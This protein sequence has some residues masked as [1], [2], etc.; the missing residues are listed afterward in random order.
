ML[1]N[2]IKYGPTLLFLW[3]ILVGFIIGFIRGFRK[4]LIL[5]INALIAF[6]IAAIIYFS[7]VNS[8]KFDSNIVTFINNILGSGKLQDMFDVPET[9]KTLSGIIE[10]RI[11]KDRDY[12]DAIYII[13]SNNGEYLKTLVSLGYHLF[14]FVLVLPIYYLLVF[15]LYIIY[16]I[17]FSERRYKNKIEQS[18]NLD[19]KYKKRMALGGVVGLVR[20]TFKGVLILS[21]LGG[22][23]YM[24][25]GTGER[26]Y[27][28]D[29]D[30]KNENYNK[31]YDCYE[32]IG[33]YGNY[34]IYKILNTAKNK[35]D[36]PYYLFAANAIFS[37]KLNDK[38]RNVNTNV[39][40]IEE[41][42]SYT[43]FTRETIDL[44]MEIDSEACINLIN[45][46][47]EE[48]RNRFYKIFENEEFQT[49]YEKIINDFDSK[50]YFT[51]LSMSLIETIASNIDKFEL[52]DGVS[53]KNL[54]LL[55]IILDKNHLSMYIDEEREAI[56]EHKTAKD[57]DVATLD[58]TN[59]LDR[60][61]TA[62]IAVALLSILAYT[63][64][65]KDF[66]NISNICQN[67]IPAITNLSILKSEKRK[68]EMDPFFSRLY[69]AINNIYLNE[70]EVSNDVSYLKK[71]I[72]YKEIKKI[73]EDYDIDWQ[74]E[75]TSLLVS[76]VDT[77]KIL[78]KV[79]VD[80]GSK[81]NATKV[82]S[83]I[84]DI[85][86]KDREDYNELYSSYTDVI[87]NIENSKLLGMVL[88]SSF[89]I[90]AISD[91][92]TEIYSE[93][94]VYDDIRFINN[95]ENYGELHHVLKA[96]EAIASDKTN[97]DILIKLVDNDFDTSTTSKILDL[98]RDISKLLNTEL[99][100]G[101]STKKASQYILNSKI[102]RSY[103][104][105][106]VFENRDLED[107]TLYIPD[108]VL[109]EV[110]GEKVNIINEYEL[111]DLFDLIPT[112]VDLIDPYF[113]ETSDNY[114]NVDYILTN[115]CNDTYITLL[116]NIIIEGTISSVAKEELADNENIIMPKKLDEIEGWISIKDDNGNVIKDGEIK[117]LAKAI[118]ISG[119]SI[120]EIMDDPSDERLLD[121]V[122]TVNEEAIDEMLNSDILVYTISNYA[123]TKD[124]DGLVIVI[125]Y[126][127]RI[128]LSD[129][130]IP[131]IITDSEIKEFVLE[132]RKVLPET[133][134]DEID[135]NDL[136][137]K[138]M[139]NR[140]TLVNSYTL[141]ATVIN[142]F[143]NDSEEIKEQIV[144]PTHLEIDGG[145][146]KTNKEGKLL[147]YNNGT[148]W[149]IELPLMLESV[150]AYA[151][152]T[153][154]DSI[155]LNDEDQT[156]IKMKSNIKILN[157]TIKS[158]YESFGKTYDGDP[159]VTVYDV[160][161]LSSVT[162][163]TISQKIDEM[164]TLETVDNPNG[165]IKPKQK[166]PLLI[167]NRVNYE[168]NIYKYYYFEEEEIY[169]LANVINELNID[170]EEIVLEDIMNQ[171]HQFNL[172]STLKMYET[173]LDKPTKLEVCYPS[174]I[175]DILLSN[176]IK[177]EIKYSSILIDNEKAKTNSL[178]NVLVYSQ[179][180]IS[181]LSGFVHE[182][183]INSL[184][185][186]K[187]K[188]I[189][190]SD[191]NLND[192]QINYLADSF[193]LNSTIAKELNSTLVISNDDFD[194]NNHIIY[195]DNLVVALNNII[196]IC[197]T[198]NAESLKNF[199]FDSL[200]L[201]ESKVNY[202]INSSIISNTVSD[203]LSNNS[204]VVINRLYVNDI[205]YII[206]N[207]GFVSNSSK[208]QII[209]TEL[210]TFLIALTNVFTNL[211]INSITDEAFNSIRLSDKK[212]YIDDSNILLN[213]VTMHIINNDTV[214]TY[215]ADIDNTKTFERINSNDD[216]YV[217]ANDELNKFFDGV[218]G[219]F[220]S[221]ITVGNINNDSINSIA[222]NGKKNYIVESNLLSNTVT[223]QI[224]DNPNVDVYISDVIETSLI[225]GNDL[226][227]KLIDN[228]LSNFLDGIVGLYGN[229]VTITYIET[230]DINTLVLNN[231]K[232]YIVNSKLLSNTVTNRIVTNEN[233]VTFKNDVN[234]LETIKETVGYELI[235]TNELDSFLSGIDSIF[236]NVTPNNIGS[237][238]SNVS[239]DSTKVNVITQSILM[240]NTVTKQIIDNESITKLATQFIED[241][242]IDDSNYYKLNNEDELSNFLNGVIGLFGEVSVSSINDEAINSLTLEGK[243][244]Y[245]NN[246]ELL[247]STVTKQ[248]VSNTNVIVL[249]DECDTVQQLTESTDG[250]MF[251]NTNELSNFID[252]FIGLFGNVSVSSITSDTINNLVLNNKKDYITN[253]C[254]LTSTVTNKI[255]TNPNI[256]VFNL[257]ASAVLKVTGGTTYIFN[258][259][260][261]LYNILNGI[262][263]LFETNITPQN[264][265]DNMDSVSLT[266]SKVEYITN[267]SILSNTVTKEI[268]DNN[269]VIKLKEDFEVRMKIQGSTYYRL[270]DSNELDSFLNGVIGLFGDVSVSSISDEAINSLTLEG[271]KDY[272]NDSK[273][274][275][276]TVTK[277][278]VDNS[279]V[280]VLFNDCAIKP[281]LNELYY[282]YEFNDSDEIS[283]FIDGFIGL[284][285]N[286]S[287]S[288]ITSDTINNLVL[289]N[290][291]DYIT[292]S[293]VLTS[294]VTNKIVTNPNIIVFNSDVNSQMTVTG[295]STYMF[296]GGV[297]LYNIL[298]G[299]D[300]LFETNITPQNVDDNIGSVT[301]T[302]DKINYITDSFILHNTVTKE[303]IENDSVVKLRSD[304]DEELLVQGNP[305]NKLKEYIE[306][307]NF[308][309]GV[310]GLFG[311][312]SINSVTETIVNNL[313]L[314][315]D[316]IK[317][318]TNSILLS[319]TVV[320]KIVSNDSIVLYKEDL[321]IIL[322]LD[323][324]EDGYKYSYEYEL[325][326]FLNGL[327]QLFGEINI[328][329]IDSNAID[330]IVLNPNNILAITDSQTLSN[331][332]SLNIL[333][334]ETVV[335][336]IDYTS[337]RTSLD[338]DTLDSYVIEN[339]ELL[340]ALSSISNL[341]KNGDNYPTISSI[342]EDRINEM[343]LNDTSKA[344]I[345]KSSIM[346][347][348]VG[349][350]IVNNED[351]V[352]TLENYIIITSVSYQTDYVI[353]TNEG[354]I[355]KL[356]LDLFLISLYRGLGITTVGDV[357][358]ENIT[359]P[360]VVDDDLTNS[361]IM[362]ATITTKI[363]FLDNNT[364]EEDYAF[365]NNTSAYINTLRY[366]KDYNQIRV[367]SATEIQY[368]IDGSNIID[369]YDEANPHV[370]DYN[371]EIGIH[372]LKAL[373]DTELQTVLT[374]SILQINISDVL[375][376][377][378]I[379]AGVTGTNI[380]A[381]RVKDSETSLINEKVVTIY[382]F[383]EV[384]AILQAAPGE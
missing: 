150:E 123:Y 20:T 102:V 18:D 75:L 100:E 345:M 238:I 350:N 186:I 270:A 163:A 362:C 148:C 189:T 309:T 234:E 169:H 202:I 211:S 25:A 113:D 61:D 97:K 115:L 144:I 92:V 66:D 334:N 348:T 122:K 285:G 33:S 303:I 233:V 192:N 83:T 284:F 282:A 272:I 214:V 330:N 133:A 253:S 369:P 117:A 181:Y 13:V 335:V 51:N 262:D 315:S 45:D 89:V 170:V 365:V 127:V 174:E 359:V 279:N 94:Y 267:S 49:R 201:T 301:I 14:V 324:S 323:S 215:E 155:D 32:S 31:I 206:Y 222:L 132:A 352:V 319:N 300:N 254:V 310:I 179:N 85:F 294:T 185:N 65:T 299:I 327:I 88:D 86:D 373:S 101:N 231:K 246:S 10:A 230:M 146:D 173:L 353:N 313:V 213:T 171:F 62:K 157:D 50:V 346:V 128:N 339:S 40:F 258:D 381:I 318:I 159:N 103:L 372:T 3:I 5:A 47:T 11:L 52:V 183:Q 140:K 82:I 105:A 42:G 382:S 118:N 261:E 176:S 145:Y 167:E 71:E 295:E 160:C 257:D 383:E 252:G 91:G 259:D 217:L 296:N 193:I 77:F 266:S 273:L 95:G 226:G 343:V 17:F 135:P 35:D 116:D 264:V 281:Q 256:I 357:S 288:S 90:D 106:Y 236:T 321:D 121:I 207:N 349:S 12:G 229:L 328:N 195:K 317:Y 293:C 286:V 351:V 9:N 329:S 212:D 16:L 364:N 376:S 342:N 232:D 197:E 29:Y 274:L 139:L 87:N 23:F 184:S 114:E 24:L 178:H 244:N 312:L 248:I 218:I 360:M 377:Y 63:S 199:S 227:Y 347:D 370:R 60:K 344:L 48:N 136:V 367:L 153:R 43:D 355:L 38:D 332:V 366:D 53:K 292:N 34:G 54:E 172:D 111:N 361:D 6:T 109:E 19:K 374:S 131:F 68:D 180:E 149:F 67:V 371:I 240:S 287:V 46:N 354:T 340:L 8:S 235:D 44:L 37:G 271:K 126:N 84:F 250:Y 151:G 291:K 363:K 333:S 306:L 307:S 188:N 196:L 161:K 220:G 56:I 39:H 224:I 166:E 263:N 190:L 278:I 70:I 187:I 280:I 96:I 168:G 314:T 73:S 275:T 298:N 165:V 305:Y 320:D 277:Q 1:D 142:Y 124:L 379:L 325:G 337:E 336:N 358:D 191:I 380:N 260:L 221:D 338:S 76:T 134:S 209:N 269:S 228:E 57:I 7:L 375:Q 243:K 112:F 79:Y 322:K 129:D 28:T 110:N 15:F 125:P 74:Q 200:V 326:F 59:I 108:S 237:K 304:F 331:T 78:D 297:E 137:K 138:T 98:I 208:Y 55:K 26:K 152:F 154:D 4:S 147:S 356:E 283:N 64:D 265:D 368:F 164:L 175:F 30:F 177:D 204:D 245:I 384:K 341:F 72:S 99:I 104:S 242:L 219:L 107:A 223:K 81:L 205:S 158:V 203:K 251:V 290:K 247:T 216:C 289:N 210:E 239:L 36:V 162:Y 311:N 194:I 41:F 308:L 249:S 27:N 156:T 255:V 93:A 225:N 22:L 241:E 268:I 378:A 143:V 130:T 198:N 80:D 141:S 69:T 120:Q 119:I 302:T 2:F 316:K 182:I 21:L 276:S 58:I